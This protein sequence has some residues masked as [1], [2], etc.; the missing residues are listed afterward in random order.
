MG[1]YKTYVVAELRSE[2][3]R[4]SLRFQLMNQ[5]F[6][7]LGRLTRKDFGQR[8]PSRDVL[9][10]GGWEPIP[11]SLFIGCGPSIAEASDALGAR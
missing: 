9:V 1:A 7:L 4:S 10:F 8:T 11:S 6:D 3:E 2:E 5:G